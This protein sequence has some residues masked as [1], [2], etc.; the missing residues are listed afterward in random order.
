MDDGARDG[1][2]VHGAA[3]YA[4]ERLIEVDAASLPAFHLIVVAAVGVG[5]EQPA[6]DA[7]FE[8]LVLEGLCMLDQE[9]LVAGEEGLGAGV[10]GGCK[11]ADVFAG[12]NACGPRRRRQWH[13]LDNTT[14]AD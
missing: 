9:P 10:A 2:E 14:E 3:V 6:V 5:V 8:L 11:F 7:L 13:V 12:D 4:A 1:V